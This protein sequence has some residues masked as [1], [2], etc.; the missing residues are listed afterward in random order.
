MR[1]GD[2]IVRLGIRIASTLLAC[3]GLFMAFASP[4]LAFATTGTGADFE[5]AWDTVIVEVNAHYRLYLHHEGN[6]V[7][8][9][10]DNTQASQYSGTLKGEV[11]DAGEA[12][13]E[14]DRRLFLATA[15]IALAA[16]SASADQNATVKLFTLHLLAVQ[17]PYVL[18]NVFCCRYRSGTGCRP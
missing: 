14:D 3:A 9:N 11:K 17:Q 16:S 7:E 12:R 8:G 18:Q 10:F 2:K 15:V 6:S 13:E 5:G 4:A 1:E